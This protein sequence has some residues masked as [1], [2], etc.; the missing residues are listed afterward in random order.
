M[1]QSPENAPRKPLPKQTRISTTLSVSG[2]DEKRQI[3]RGRRFSAAYRRFVIAVTAKKS[4]STGTSSVRLPDLAAELNIPV[5][6]LQPLLDHEYLRRI[7]FDA[8]IRPEP[9]AMAWLRT[10]F[11]PLPL[12]PCL[13]SAMVSDIVDCTTAELR[14]LCLMYDIPLQSDPVF[15]ELMSISSFHRFLNA[16]HHFKE[17]TRLDRQGLMEMLLEALPY[18]EGFERAIP[19]LKFSQRL[20]MEIRRI[21]RLP[22]PDRTMRAVAFL[23]A[24]RDAKSITDAWTRYQSLTS[25]EIQGM[26]RLEK[27][28]AKSVGVQTASPE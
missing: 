25:P 21:A 11:L 10:M 16:Y 26:E 14:T 3:S 22:E 4:C 1:D 18:G 13:T 27:L 20:D 8:V 15:G 7:A 28:V 17:P 5:E 24:Y 23:G 12:R 19:N 9:E 2:V 6:R